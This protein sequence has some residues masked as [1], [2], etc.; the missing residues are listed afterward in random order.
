MFPFL[1]ANKF[2][3]FSYLLVTSLITGSYFIT[4]NFGSNSGKEKIQFLWNQE[5]LERAEY[6]NALMNEYAE[7]EI[8]HRLAIRN[9][10]NELNK[11]K[12]SYN[13]TIASIE[14]EYS[15]RLQ[16][17]SNR[18]RIYK[19]QAESGATGCRFL[20]EHTG[21]LDQSLTEGR[22]LVGELTETVKQCG[23]GVNLLVN[24]IEA[25]RELLD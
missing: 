21:R 5:K 3:I 9:I 8:K 18:E 6:T 24:F 19:R 11:V 25:D 17:S 16:Q 1:I 12:S 7:K 14:L 22:R 20:S 4:Y 23:A 2:K 15:D 13:E 10:E